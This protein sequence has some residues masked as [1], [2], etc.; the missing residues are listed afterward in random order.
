MGRK[1]SN[2]TKSN[3]T[4]RMVEDMI[5]DLMSKGSFENP[6]GYVYYVF[7]ISSIF[8]NTMD[9]MVEDM[10]LESMS[11]GSFENLPGYGYSKTFVKQPLQKKLK[12]RS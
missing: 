7:C 6:P 8:S 1:E 9:R 11:K 2:Q 5:L 10:I 12:Q 3:P 4:D